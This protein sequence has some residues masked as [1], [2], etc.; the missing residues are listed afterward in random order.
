IDELVKNDRGGKLEA[1]AA[2]RRLESD[3]AARN[4][5][6]G[7]NPLANQRKWMTDLKAFLD[8]YPRSEEAPDALLRL[9]GALEFN[10]EE[11]E[12]RAYYGRLAREFPGTEPGKKATGALRRLDL[13]GKPLV[14]KGTGLK[15]ET[16]D[17]AQYQG[18]QLLVV[19][20][21]TWLP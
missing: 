1:F 6:Q 13:V 2:F 8:R 20:W 7:S 15:N 4:D 14:L 16:V 12:A 5:E 9:A 10:A 21:A 18:K 11:D 17:A 19:F 3:F